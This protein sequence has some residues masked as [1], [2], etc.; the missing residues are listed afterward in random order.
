VTP[1]PQQPDACDSTFEFAQK[2]TDLV[3]YRPTRFSGFSNTAKMTIVP[4]LRAV[5]AVM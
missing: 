3:E 4:A 1:L 2:P 5:A